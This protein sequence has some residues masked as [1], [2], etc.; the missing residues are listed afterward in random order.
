MT[1][2]ELSTRYITHSFELE[3]HIEGFVD[4]YFGP[5]ELQN[6]ASA[7]PP[8]A[9]AADLFTLRDSVHASDY[10]PR[11]KQYLDAQLRAMQANARKLAGEAISYRDEVRLLFDIEPHHTAETVFE[12]AIAELDEL[13]PG[14]GPVAARMET[15]RQQFEAPSQIARQMIE[16]IAAEARTRTATLIPL[17]ADETVS[18]EFVSDKPWGGYNWYLGAARSRVDINTDLPI[19]ADSLLNLVCH[20]AYP[21][22][23]TE[24][25]LK[26]QQ[27]YVERGWGEHA[28]QLINA[29]ESVI[30]EGIATLAADI[31]FGDE[32]KIWTNATIY[33]LGGI[34]GDPEREQR[35]DKAN[36]LLRS[37]S[38]NAA[39]LLHEQGAD[40]EDVVQYIMRYGLRTERE[41]RQSLR[42][43]S[44]PLWRSYIFT[45]TAGRTLLG[46]W[47]QRGDRAERFRTLLTE[48]IYPSLI[49]QWTLEEERNCVGA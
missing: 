28:I 22:H 42:F 39:L 2:D 5:P 31:I 49:E 26:E 12:E 35:I 19:R 45:Y 9:I 10:P 38:G 20:E 4:A 3:Q 29:P 37:L 21:G 16:Q 8:E 30:S 47:L 48:P 7:R 36:W 46:R 17:P 6:V 32:A 33:P 25:S 1:L 18:F 23:H 41:A 43:I 13:L 11:R 27:L 15:W 34:M 40:P 14:N 24:H 44:T